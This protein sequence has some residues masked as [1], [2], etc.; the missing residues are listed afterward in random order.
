MITTMK[1]TKARLKRLI[2]EEM[3]KELAADFV[4]NDIIDYLIKIGSIEAPN[5]EEGY[6][7][8][9]DRVYR[10][11]ATFLEQFAIPYLRQMAD[12]IERA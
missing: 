9:M 5:D 10:D 3:N 2:K 12:V 6:D 4:E 1:I 7:S 8:D 11:A